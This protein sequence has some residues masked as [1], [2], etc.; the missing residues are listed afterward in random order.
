MTPAEVKAIEKVADIIPVSKKDAQFSLTNCVRVGSIIYNGTGISE[1]KINDEDYASEKHKN[2]S[3][4]K[5]CCDKGVSLVWI[6]LSEF[7]KSGAA[8]SCMVL[9]LNK[10]AYKSST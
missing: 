1:M 4:E 3:L 2:E 9:F 10:P 6:N 7:Q 5:I 8:A